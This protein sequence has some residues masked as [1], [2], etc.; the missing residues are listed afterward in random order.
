[1]QVTYVQEA[2]HYTWTFGNFL[3]TIDIQRAFP[4]CIT[5]QGT[6]WQRRAALD[7]SDPD[8]SSR[9][10]MRLVCLSNNNA[11]HKE[12][13]GKS[14]ARECRGLK[15]LSSNIFGLIRKRFSICC[16]QNQ[17]KLWLV[18][19]LLLLVCIQPENCTLADVKDNLEYY[20]KI[21]HIYTFFRLCVN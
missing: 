14:L 6:L 17:S 3:F 1:M 16:H 20:S 15:G 13:K 19:P 7:A 9:R 2:A 10:Q 21:K 5:I 12:C 4:L 8:G 11:V 18:R